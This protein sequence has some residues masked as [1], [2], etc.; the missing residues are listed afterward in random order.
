MKH[1]LLLLVLAIAAP[2]QASA[3]ESWQ[4]VYVTRTSDLQVTS[5]QAILTRSGNRLTGELTGQ[6]NVQFSIDAR[7]TGD[8]VTATFGSLESDD[9]G[10][11]LNGTFR[12]LTMSVLGGSSCW[13]TFQLSDGFSSL[14]LARNASRCEP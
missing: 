12:Q 1:S 14:A 3:P 9:G 2:V 6:H 4:F 10:T 11:R 5:G 8:K 13:Q 7:I